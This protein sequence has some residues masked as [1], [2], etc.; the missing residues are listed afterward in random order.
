MANEFKPTPSQEAAMTLRD[1]LI[2]IS[3]AAGSGKTRVLTERIISQLVEHTADLSRILVVTFTRAAAAEL[4]SRIAKALG[5]A[6]AKK[7]DDTY[8]SNQL[9]LLGGAQIS[10]YDSFFISVIREHFE[11]LGLPSNFRIADQ[12]ESAALSSEILNEVMGELYDEYAPKNNSLPFAKIQKNEFASAMNNL[13]GNRRDTGIDHHLLDLFNDLRAYPEGP[14]LLNIWAKNLESAA[15][16]DFLKSPMCE[17]LVKDLLE[18]LDFFNSRLEKTE[19]SF[20]SDP[21]FKKVFY[22]V[23]SEDQAFC[24]GMT[25]ALNEKSYE[26]AR[27]TLLSFNPKDF[28]RKKG[29]SPEE[30]EFFHSTRLQIKAFAD[31][32]R[33]EIFKSPSEQIPDQLL[34]AAS[35]NRMLYQLFTRFD[36]RIMEEKKRRGIL[37]FNDV[38]TLLYRLLTLQDGSASPVAKALSERYDA[39]YI[40]EFQD[41]DYM[42]DSIF[43]LIG[44]NRRFMVGDIKQSIYGFRGSEPSIFSEYR[45][46]MPLHDSEKAKNTNSVCVF[47]SENFRCQRPIINYANA[48]CSYLFSACKSLTYLPEDDLVCKKTPDDVPTESLP[49]V[50][51]VAFEAFKR[52]K[53]MTEED[54]ENGKNR[55]ARWIAAE[56]SRLLREETDEKGNPVY[57]PSDIAILVRRKKHG[58]P[59]C[60][61][62]RK[63]NIPVSAPDTD[64][65]L[66]TSL[67]TCILNLLRSVDNPYR[68]Y[69]LSEYLQSE[70][71]GFTLDELTRIK[72]SAPETC[73]LFEAMELV[74]ENTE[75]PEEKKVGKTVAWIKKQMELASV[76]SADRFL[77]LLCLE[78]LFSPLVGTPE[79]LYLREQ[80]KAY[81]ENAWC[82]LYGFLD[83]FTALLNGDGESAAGLKQAE[84]AVQIMTIHHSKGLE[85]PIIFVANCGAGDTHQERA[86]FRFHRRVGLASTLYNPITKGNDHPILLRVVDAECDR[87]ESEEK[88]RTL[89]VAL[90]RAQ[91]RLYV[92]GTSRKSLANLLASAEDLRYGSADSILKCEYFLEWVIAA[93]LYYQR[94]NGEFPCNFR[95]IDLS[96]Q[97][98]GAPLPTD[99][100]LPKPV[101]PKE[102]DEIEFDPEPYRE[103]L[104]KKQDFSYPL[105]RLRRLP[106]KLAA[107][108]V[109]PNLLDPLLRDQSDSSE[110]FMNEKAEKQAIELRIKMM[111]SVTP[112]FE[113]LLKREGDASATQIGTA[114]HAFMEFFDPHRLLLNGTDAE[115]EYLGSEEN[116]FIDRETANLLNRKWI[117]ALSKSDLM[118]RILSA[119][120]ILR[121]QKFS[122]LMPLSELSEKAKDDEVLRASSIFVQGSIDLILRM[123]D[124][125]LILYDYKTDRVGEEEGAND[126]KLSKGFLQH[127]GDQL[128]CYARAIE[129]YFGKRPDEIYIYSMPLGR[130]VKMKLD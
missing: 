32:L 103:I 81:Q 19:Y 13:M 83:R 94:K 71:G 97:I 73:S 8:L 54:L 41:T 23:F 75:F 117:N 24:V 66:T 107:S 35:L 80:A 31:N 44:G 30:R 39:V 63:L 55:E 21:E 112:P 43:R 34:R 14:E 10:T 29:G 38:R 76:L 62:L 91:E 120:E 40:D 65:I 5:E 130:S 84:D 90:T 79:I 108:K 18:P 17:N 106:T 16:T 123:P 70:F 69:P 96:E 56:I 60:E 119:K 89:Y 85:R 33:E 42:Q 57:S 26:K 2:L 121:E 53:G 116:K 125:S 64:N 67:M 51:T 113:A 126:T 86:K 20:D 28:P 74:A 77:R 102:N 82:G 7:P 111:E 59:I 68:D 128:R 104:A 122:L 105:E 49:A 95:T 22:E 36:G 25:N 15:K 48:V 3:A 61:A 118:D 92:T 109:R 50:E 9:F 45:D 6:L 127:H 114:M 110:Q 58:E 93:I 27:E 87:D 100:K 72:R 4:K 129:N 1:K 47:M 11:E 124:G 88:I 101:R 37:E 98:C 78:P 99:K 115:I 52:S 46:S 12:S